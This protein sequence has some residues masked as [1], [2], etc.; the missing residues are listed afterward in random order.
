MT[1]V[2][3]VRLEE[4]RCCHDCVA[5]S[6]AGHRIQSNNNYVFAWVQDPLI[7][8]LMRRYWDLS[9]QKKIKHLYSPS[10]KCIAYWRD[11]DFHKI[12]LEE[13]K[14]NIAKDSDL[15]AFLCKISII[16]QGSVSYPLDI[17]SNII[18]F[19]DSFANLVSGQSH[20]SGLQVMVTMYD[21]ILVDNP[22]AVQAK[23][24]FAAYIAVNQYKKIQMPRKIDLM[25]A[26]DE[27]RNLAK[28][29]EGRFISIYARKLIELD[30]IYSDLVDDYNKSGI[31]DGAFQIC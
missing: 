13:Y 3:P 7:N 21:G 18:L 8:R 2:S 26:F 14:E 12:D 1:I 31:N 4:I 23:L 20:S 29:F 28:L 5:A 15:L 25:N 9:N 11:L 27:I 6:M 30:K 24:L 17:A 19:H 16:N 10:S 22:L